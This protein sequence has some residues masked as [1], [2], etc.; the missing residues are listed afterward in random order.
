VGDWPVRGQRKLEYDVVLAG[1]Q[2]DWYDAADLYRDWSLQ[3][4]WATPLH[5]RRDIPQWLLDSPVHITVRLQG[6]IDVGPTFPVREFLPYEK[7][8]P[9]LDKI[10]KRVEA[11]L[12]TIIMSW[13]HAGPWIYPDCFP[14]IGGDQSVTRFAQMA[15]KRG[16]HVGSFCNGTRWVTSHSWNQYDG[17]KF[18]KDHDGESSICRTPDG[19]LW[20]EEWGWRFAY[21]QCMGT[22]LTRQIAVEFVRRLIGWGLESIQF[23]DQNCCAETF[24]CFASDHEHPPVPGKWM[25][26]KMRELIGSFQAAAKAA[27]EPGVINSVERPCNETCLPLFQQ[28]DLRVVPPGHWNGPN[29]LPLYHYLYH[30]CIIL[31]GM[32]GFGPEPYNLPIRNAYNL[33][34]GENVGAVMIGDGT[35]LNKDTDNWAPWREQVGNNDDALEMLRTAAALRRG[36]GK[37]FLVFGRMQRPAK[38]SGIK[39]ITWENAGRVNKM[40]AVF[41][42]AWQAPDGRLGLVLANWTTQRQVVNVTD[43]RWRQAKSLIVSGPKL[44][45]KK[46]TKGRGGLKVAL[47]ALSCALIV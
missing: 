42:A 44:T 47:P 17:T 5:Q 36:P 33:V 23:F 2:G 29:F 4:P 21:L 45:T 31:H 6:E 38:I 32:M 8:I 34:L 13:E 15:R 41:Q 18:F 35:L 27:G 12:A 1:F 9:L 37:D 28:C 26:A 7:T 40:P 30:E 46:L 19:K 22:P 39:T 16:W 25:A 14:P 11:P 3:Q 10:A 24:P 43:A 20:P